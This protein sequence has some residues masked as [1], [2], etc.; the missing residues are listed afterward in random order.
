[1]GA[2]PR[3][4]PLLPTVDLA[5]VPKAEASGV[6]ELPNG[7]T[8]DLTAGLVKREIAGREILMFG[9]NGQ[10][11]GPLI[12]VGQQST[13]FVNFTNDTPFPTSVHWHGVRLD[14]RYD[15]VPGVTQDP[16]EPGA[17]FRYQIYFRDA[18][19]Y[20]YHP[21]HREDVQQELGLAGNLCRCTGYYP[22]MAAVSMAAERMRP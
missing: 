6:V 3:A 14:N 21:H 18:G 5:D 16:V 13:I 15:G 1:M 19:I 17:T 4:S 12:S 2:R 7:G 10:I 9:F 20:W 11:P 22:I 8:V